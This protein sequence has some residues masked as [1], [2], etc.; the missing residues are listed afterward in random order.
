MPPEIL[1]ATPPVGVV[2]F[3]G[4]NVDLRAHL[5]GFPYEPVAIDPRAN[6][7]LVDH[8]GEHRTLTSVALDATDPASGRPIGD[9]DWDT[10]SRWSVRWH[11]ASHSWLFLGDTNNDERLNLWRLD[12]VTGVSTALTDEPYTYGYSVAPDGRIAT[13]PR[14][15]AAAAGDY[16][17]CVE[18]LDKDAS[19][20]T[21]IVCDGGEGHRPPAGSDAGA[22]PHQQHLA[23]IAADAHPG[24]H[25]HHPFGGHHQ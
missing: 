15:P 12:P 16:R 14:R 9:T 24:G 1:G 19:T 8:T 2:A 22:V 21:P 6:Q 3:Q 10:R 23:I 25:D 20:R 5:E 4:R 7:L 13:I 17:S 18:V 11:D